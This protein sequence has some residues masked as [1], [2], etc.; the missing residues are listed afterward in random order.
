MNHLEVFYMFLCKGRVL[1]S[2]SE[3]LD[4]ISSGEDALDVEKM[5]CVIT[6]CLLREE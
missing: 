4:S 6:L 2:T 5:H 3:I 1:E